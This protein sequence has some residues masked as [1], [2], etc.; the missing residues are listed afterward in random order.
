MC[1][2][3]NPVA[4]FRLVVFFN[5]V[6]RIFKLGTVPESMNHT[7]KLFHAAVVVC[8]LAIFLA[9]SHG[10]LVDLPDDKGGGRHPK[11]DA[12]SSPHTT[13]ASSDVGDK[14]RITTPKINDATTVHGNH[15]PVDSKFDKCYKDC[16]QDDDDVNLQHYCYRQCMFDPDSVF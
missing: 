10:F 13:R 3:P 2:T 14:G 7:G 1:F 4:F 15:K 5:S 8:L 12:T 9:S 6:K 16:Y 11:P